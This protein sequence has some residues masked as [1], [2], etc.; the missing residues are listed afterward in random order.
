MNKFYQGQS[1]LMLIFCFKIYYMV[2]ISSKRYPFATI[3]VF[4]T[5]FILN[6]T[7]YKN[8]NIVQILTDASSA[9]QQNV[10]HFI[11]GIVRMTGHNLKV[12]K[13]G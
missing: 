9:L 6:C 4:F 1:L 5:L 11:F 2:K 13:V 7:Q 10:L 12:W 8:E 3:I